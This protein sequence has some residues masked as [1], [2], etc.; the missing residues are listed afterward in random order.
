MWKRKKATGNQQTMLLLRIPNFFFLFHRQAS[1]FQTG[2][3][4]GKVW[5]VCSLFFDNHRN[6]ILPHLF[7]CCK[8]AKSSKASFLFREEKRREKEKG[9]RRRNRKKNRKERERVGERK[10]KS[11]NRRKEI[12]NT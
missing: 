7:F 10:H 12:K 9:R 1:P 11:G 4:G 8:E 3:V 6:I 5:T 2:W